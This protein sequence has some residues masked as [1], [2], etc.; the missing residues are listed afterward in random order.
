MS[1]SRAQRHSGRSIGLVLAAATA[2]LLLAGGEALASHVECGETITQDTT[3][4]SHVVCGDP[5]GD[6]LIIGADNV[7]LDLNHFTV[8]ASCNEFR[9]SVLNLGYDGVTIRNGTLDAFFGVT[10]SGV[11]GNHLQDLTIRACV[12]GPGVRLSGSDRNVIENTDVSTYRG[13]GMILDDSDNNRLVGNG[14]SV[15]LL[16]SNHNWIERTGAPSLYESHHNR[17]IRSAGASLRRS[18]HNR[19]EKNVGQGGFAAVHLTESHQNRI[20]GND[21]STHGYEPYPGGQY[22]DGAGIWL[23]RSDRN[24]IVGNVSRDN[25]FDGIHLL[26]SANNVVRGN[27]AS[28]N[29]R[30]GI[31]IDGFSRKTLLRKNVAHENGDDGVDVE[32]A[33]TVVT[34]NT[35]NFNLDLG[36]EAVSG[37]RKAKGNRA[38][39]NGNPAQC[40]NI[41]CK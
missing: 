40:A 37:L 21:V 14:A 2:W 36:I 3:L 17:I 33:D 8:F 19:I 29:G 30:D 32:S 16:G 4:D 28:H 20:A 10:A 27:A 26:S 23:E 41:A 12:E 39:G 11:S 24:E 38:E 7:T 1:L 22:D 6:A 5:D 25:V 31:F 9:S 18:H 13:T 35:A 34:R 15:A